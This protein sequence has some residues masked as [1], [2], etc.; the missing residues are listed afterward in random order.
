[1]SEHDTQ[2]AL[3]EWV[4]RFKSRYPALGRIYAVP[5]GGFR[6]PSVASWLKKEGVRPGVLDLALPVPRRGKHGMYLELKYGRN[7]PTPEQ[8]V[9]IESLRKDGYY[10]PDP[11]YSWIEA[12]HKIA[13]YLGIDGDD[14]LPER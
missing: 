7:K 13:W 9:E 14:I 10:V 4:E 11:C 3:M 8:A 1:M 12:A 5:N 6:H 2:V